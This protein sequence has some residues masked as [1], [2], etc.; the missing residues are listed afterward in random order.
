MREISA[1]VEIK[2]IK[3]HGYRLKSAKE[4]TIKIKIKIIACE[5]ENISLTRIKSEY[6]IN[7]LKVLK[8]IFYN[9]LHAGKEYRV[10]RIRDDIIVRCKVERARLM[11]MHELT[12]KTKQLKERCKYKT[13]LVHLKRETCSMHTQHSR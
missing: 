3:V 13:K 5:C 8:F 7:S 4:I 9:Y 10:R 2:C 12:E 6:A 11:P 1:I